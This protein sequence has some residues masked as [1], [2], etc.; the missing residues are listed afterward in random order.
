M[1]YPGFENSQAVCL[2]KQKK[3]Q[4]ER[5]ELTNLAVLVLFFILIHHR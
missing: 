4:S 3:D 5:M 2:L 1:K